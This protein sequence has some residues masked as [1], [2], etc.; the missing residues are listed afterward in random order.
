MESNSLRS[1]FNIIVKWCINIERFPPFMRGE[2][3]YI[4][5]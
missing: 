4:K 3:S 1:F 5:N 2:Y